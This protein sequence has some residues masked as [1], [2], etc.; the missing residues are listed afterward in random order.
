MGLGLDYFLSNSFF[1]EIKKFS[2]TCNT[3]YQLL[4]MSQ[5]VTQ[6]PLSKIFDLLCDISYPKK[7]EESII[8]FFNKKTEPKECLTE[9]S[10]LVERCYKENKF[11]QFYPLIS[12]IAQNA[13][14][15]IAETPYEISIIQSIH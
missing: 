7:A 4:S 2:K 9:I 11:D 14:Q 15:Q 5:S 13:N 12:R 1:F 8:N 6:I 10:A 3:F